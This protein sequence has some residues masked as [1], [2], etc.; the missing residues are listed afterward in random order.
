MTDTLW[1]ASEIAAVTQGRMTGDDFPVSGISI[2]TREIMPGDLFIALKGHNGDGHDFIESAL[3]QGAAGALA[4][5]E[6]IS[7]LARSRVIQVDDTFRALHDLGAGARARSNARTIAVTGSVGK[8]SVKA[9]L[10]EAFS[11]FGKTHSASASLN[12]HWGVPLSLARMPPDSAYAVFEIGM[13]HAGE[14]TPL[15]KLVSPHIAIITTVAAAH[16]QHFDSVEAIALAKAE[17]FQG[18]DADGMAILP[19]DNE[20]FPILL[21]EA[22]TQGIRTII[23]FGTHKDADVRLVSYNDNMLEVQFGDVRKTF[24]LGIAGRHQALNVLSVLASLHAAGLD[25][26][27]SLG[28]FEK[29]SPVAGRGNCRR[30]QLSGQNGTVTAIDETHNASPVAVEAALSVLSGINGTGRRVIVLGDMLELGEKSE[31]LHAGLAPFVMAARPDAVYLC[32]KMMAHL[33]ASL[34][35]GICFHYTDSQELTDAL[36]PGLQDG[37]ML[38]VKGSRGSKMKRVIDALEQMAQS[39]TTPQ[40]AHSHATATTG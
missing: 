30:F 5:R 25:W 1:T 36:L 17:I 4:H 2:D 3:Q 11:F 29:M 39:G 40:N 19:R 14:I 12:N 28:V 7:A 18:M 35:P 38:L 37:D 9:M 34:P 8:T 21:A 10:H 26:T 20:F 6:G 27:Q 31:A 24:A 16:I 32:G 23:T 13:N 15:S 33:A 22:R